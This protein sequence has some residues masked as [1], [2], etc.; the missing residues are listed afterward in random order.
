MWGSG[1]LGFGFWHW[2]LGLGFESLG[3]SGFRAFG[4]LGF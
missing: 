3:V 2:D 1:V 4:G